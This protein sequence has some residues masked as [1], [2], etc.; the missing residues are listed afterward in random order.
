MVKLESYMSA[1]VLIEDHLIF[2]KWCVTKVAHCS[3]KIFLFLALVVILFNGANSLCN[4]G[5]EYYRD[6]SYE[7]I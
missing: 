1:H 3:L 2:Y 4:F 6:H 7:I 5:R